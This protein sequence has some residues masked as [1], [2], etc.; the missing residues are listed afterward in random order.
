MRVPVAGRR[1]FRSYT[2]GINVAMIGIVTEERVR[3]RYGE[4]DQMGHAYYSNYL[5]WYEQARGAWCRDRGFT[6]KGLEEDGFRLP[7]VEVWTR[8]RGEIKYDDVAVVRVKLAEIKRSAVKFEY[9]V[10]NERTGQECT[11]GYTWHVLAAGEPIKAIA[12]PDDVM[13]M[14]MRDPG[15]HETSG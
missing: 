6:Y 15:E 5:L 8:Y 10:I 11:K 3:V 4:T 14:L 7:V 1:W 13:E 9:E 12:I 2:T